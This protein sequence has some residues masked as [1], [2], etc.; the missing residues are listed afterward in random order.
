MVISEINYDLIYSNAYEIAKFGPPKSIS[1]P[2]RN[3]ILTKTP[4]LASNSA[5]QSA[6]TYVLQPDKM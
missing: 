3:K 5:N 1:Y 2:V 4:I 6:M